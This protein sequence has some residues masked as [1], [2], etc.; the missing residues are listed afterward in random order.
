MVWT[1]AYNTTAIGIYILLE[2]L[3]HHT[4]PPPPPR[5]DTKDADLHD[6]PPLRLAQAPALFE[7]VNRN[8]LVIF[9]F[10]RTS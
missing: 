1:A 6:P 7:A 8:G 5:D 4:A 3:Q 9:L 2:M 10:V